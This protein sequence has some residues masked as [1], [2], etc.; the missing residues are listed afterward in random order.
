MDK[1]LISSIVLSR[2]K[3]IG[4]RTFK[5][6]VDY[7]GSAQKVLNGQI[8]KDIEE[9]CGTS[10]LRILDSIKREDFEKAVIEVEIAQKMNVNLIYYT[11]EEYPFLLRNIPDPPAILYIKGRYPNNTNLLSV[12]GTRK[13]SSYGKY[14]VE[15]IVRPIAKSDISIVSG[16]ATGIDALSHK[17]AIEE[18]RYTL[19]VLG[20]GIDVIYP[21]ENKKLYQEIQENGCIISEFPFGTQPSKYTFPLRNRV[22]AGLSYATLVVEAP[23]KSGSLITARLAFDYSRIVFT[24]PASINLPSAA[25]NNKLIKEN[26]AL[27]VTSQED[28]FSNLPFLKNQNRQTKPFI[29]LSEKEEKILEFLNQPRYLD[30][31][32]EM[33]SFDPDIDTILFRLTTHNLIREEGNFYYRIG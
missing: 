27:P 7:F 11:S 21:P 30:D 22:I 6:L 16:F 24:V 19:A 4:S 18:G 10:I 32:L 28:I 5:R 1:E 23:E 33:F 13:P 14:I 8:S 15:K 29:Q 2:L 31:I 20:N 9:V 3:G 12:V 17:V 25:G 26:I